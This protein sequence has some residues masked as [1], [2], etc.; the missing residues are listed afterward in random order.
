MLACHSHVVLVHSLI[1][2]SS[3][4]PFRV[5]AD[6]GR[7]KTILNIF[8][9]YRCHF[10]GLDRQIVSKYK[11]CVDLKTTLEGPGGLNKKA[12]LSLTNPRDAC[13][14]FARFT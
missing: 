10:A 9:R 14:K 1:V 11:N 8:K 12:Q 7:A 2:E 4:P 5:F 6:T 3:V 13:E